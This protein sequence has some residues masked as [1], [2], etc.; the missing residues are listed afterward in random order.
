LSEVERRQRAL[1]LERRCLV[2]LQALVEAA[3]LMRLVVEVLHC[4][5]VE[6]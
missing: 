3:A 6:Q 1:R 4:L 2:P 5:V